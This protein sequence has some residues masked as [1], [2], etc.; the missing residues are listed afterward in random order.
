M[1]NTITKDILIEELVERYPKSVSFLM[2]KGVKCIACGEPVW[3][4]LEAAAIE[5][6]II[7]DQIKEIVKELN[8]LIQKE[9]L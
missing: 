8:V 9:E 4:T 1:P 7:D 2:E 6:G 5:K 3:G